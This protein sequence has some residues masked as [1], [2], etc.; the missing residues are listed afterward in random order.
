MHRSILE[1]LAGICQR[2]FCHGAAG[3]SSL[4]FGRV[5]GHHRLSQ[6]FRF[7]EAR[8]GC[9]PNRN[10]SALHGFFF[11]C[12]SCKGVLPVFAIWRGLAVSSAR[13]GW[14]YP[15]IGQPHMA[16]AKLP[17]LEATKKLCFFQDTG[18]DPQTCHRCIH[19]RRPKECPQPDL[20]EQQ[21]CCTT[22][23]SWS[24]RA[25]TLL[26]FDPNPWMQ[27][28]GP[29]W[30]VSSGSAR[31]RIQPMMPWPQGFFNGGGRTKMIPESR[32][33]FQFPLRVGVRRRG[34]LQGSCVVLRPTFSSDAGLT[35]S[36]RRKTRH[37]PA[38]GTV[39]MSIAVLE[40]LVVKKQ[41]AWMCISYVG[42]CRACFGTG[43]C[44][45]HP[46]ENKTN[47]LACNV[48]S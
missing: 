10:S 6:R 17:G 47:W 31:L 27:C 21:C 38:E 5:G 44:G 32:T 43:G 37:C 45:T 14:G 40:P 19:R 12:K 41:T 35:S 34:W 36:T 3:G 23:T 48:Q 1:L 42:G 24:P 20:R 4:K 26:H 8:G 46:P 2:S 13:A 16:P 7:L 9:R 11:K 33:A 15:C 28:S 29:W 39:Q 30:P 25:K 22:S 18:L